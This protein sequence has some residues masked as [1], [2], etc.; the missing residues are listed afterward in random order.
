MAW[1]NSEMRLAQHYF[2]VKSTRTQSTFLIWIFYIRFFNDASVSTLFKQQS[3]HSSTNCPFVFAYFAVCQTINQ[4]HEINDVK[5]KN[6]HT[7]SVRLRVFTKFLSLEWKKKTFV[8]KCEWKKK[9]TFR[10]KFQ[11]IT[12]KNDEKMKHASHWNDNIG[13]CWKKYSHHRLL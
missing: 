10:R 2:V 7:N 9:K 11:Q 6:T 5:H 1:T 12:K 3:Q 8:W 13:D 4:H